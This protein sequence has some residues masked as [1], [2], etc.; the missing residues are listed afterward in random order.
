MRC[1]ADLHI[2]VTQTQFLV[3]VVAPIIASRKKLLQTLRGTCVA[4]EGF[5]FLLVSSTK[6][7]KE[8]NE[9]VEANMDLI[10]AAVVT[11]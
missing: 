6:I 1:C 9:G 8:G 7:N 2:C 10:Q 4:W 5:D 11:K 3:V